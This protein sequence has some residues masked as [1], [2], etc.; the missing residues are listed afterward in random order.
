MLQIVGK[1]FL[2]INGLFFLPE[3]LIVGQKGSSSK[4]SSARKSALATASTASSFVV[5]NTAFA[6]Q[7]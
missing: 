4:K 7:Q 6:F 3:R 2:Q 1:S 5:A